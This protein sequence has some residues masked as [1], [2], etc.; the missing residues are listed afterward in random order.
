MTT[1]VSPITTSFSHFVKNL[2]I[3]QGATRSPLLGMSTFDHNDPP[4]QCDVSS[5][6]ANLRRQV[7]FFEGLHLV[8]VEAELWN[9]ISHHV[10]TFSAAT[11]TVEKA[12]SYGDVMQLS[13]QSVELTSFINRLNVLIGG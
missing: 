9:E 8:T 3:P 5:E 13:G 10:E 7:H 4:I 1:P 12:R 6:A 2:V 11:T